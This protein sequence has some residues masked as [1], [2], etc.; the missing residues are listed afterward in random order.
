MM[1]RNF[2]AV[3][4]NIHTKL[5][6][7]TIIFDV[8]SKS[9]AEEEEA[10]KQVETASDK[11]YKRDDSICHNG[12]SWCHTSTFINRI[13]VARRGCGQGEV[14]SLVCPKSSRGGF[15]SHECSYGYQTGVTS[16]VLPG[17][18]PSEPIVYR[19]KNKTMER[20]VIKHIS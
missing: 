3:V 2:T 10:H 19:Q 12:E 1:K 20:E 18:A 13:V 9:K 16:A 8:H 5:K 11:R 14:P 6:I 4:I 17:P 7:E 15:L